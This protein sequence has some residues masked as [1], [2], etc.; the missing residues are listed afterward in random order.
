MARKHNYKK[1]AYQW[2]ADGFASVKAEE[3]IRVFGKKAYDALP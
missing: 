3:Y 1:P 2:E